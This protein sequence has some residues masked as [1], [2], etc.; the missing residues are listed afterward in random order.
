MLVDMNTVPQCMVVSSPFSARLPINP[1]A[2]DEQSFRAS[3]ARQL[4]WHREMTDDNYIGTRSS[5]ELKP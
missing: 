1:N 3:I 2:A 5:T 4:H